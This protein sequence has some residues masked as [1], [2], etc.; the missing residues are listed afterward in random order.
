MK[1]TPL[2]LLLSSG[3]DDTV[4]LL[5]SM[6]SGFAVTSLGSIEEIVELLQDTTL[7]RTPVDFIIVDD[8][9][10]ERVNHLAS[11]LQS[12]RSASTASTKLIHLFTPT[13]NSISRISQQAMVEGTQSGIVRV[14]KPPRQA[15]LLQT[16][17]TLKDVPSFANIGPQSEVAKAL[18]D[19]AIA[20]RLLF[21]NVLIAEGLSR[22]MTTFVFVVAN[23]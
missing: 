6:L 14:T 17:A 23:K 22:K 15:R 10:E 3:S 19:L 8:Q 2:Q 11:V 5:Q 21:G 13:S 4:A 1:P 12:S 9:S 18:N 20:K 7:K 16:L